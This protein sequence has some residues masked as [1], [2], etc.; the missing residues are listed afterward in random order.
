MGFEWVRNVLNRAGAARQQSRGMAVLAVTA[1]ETE[2][3]TL[4]H[5]ASVRNW[6][7]RFASGNEEAIRVLREHAFAVVLCDR[8]VLGENWRAHLDAVHS[9]CAAA[10]II[11]ISRVYDD[12]LWNE[13]I[14]HGGYDILTKPLQEGRVESA[15][16]SALLRWKHLAATR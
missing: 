7:L 14:R 2:R 4:E 1:S 8:D 6:D 16:A 11:L 10:S 9:A 15:F 5:V 3:R 12:Y 13:V